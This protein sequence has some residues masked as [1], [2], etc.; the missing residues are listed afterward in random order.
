MGKQGMDITELK[1]EITRLKALIAEKEE[2]L[3]RAEQRAIAADNASIAST[4][5]A[6]HLLICPFCG[7]EV[8]HASLGHKGCYMTGCH[9]NG[10][11]THNDWVRACIANGASIAE[12]Y[13]KNI[14]LK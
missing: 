13:R 9:T 8:A 14:V 7:L 3:F 10:F 1:E 2:L 12:F 6:T 5:G 11:K 4:I